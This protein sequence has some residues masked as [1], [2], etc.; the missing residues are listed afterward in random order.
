MEDAD[1]AAAPASVVP[2]VPQRRGR[3]TRPVTFINIQTPGMAL[4]LSGQWRA[5]E[6]GRLTLDQPEDIAAMRKHAW[7]GS[8]ILE[9]P[10]MASQIATQ[11]LFYGRQRL[12]QR[13]LASDAQSPSREMGGREFGPDPETELARFPV[14]GRAARR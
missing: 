3:R 5:F 2:P 14:R 8:Q 6:D 10:K 7:Y 11:Q 1:D 13:E 9:I 12:R 4:L